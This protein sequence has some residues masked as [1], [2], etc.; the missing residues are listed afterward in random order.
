MHLLHHH[1]GTLCHA[2]ALASDLSAAAARFWV[3]R[4]VCPASGCQFWADD[5]GDGGVLKYANPKP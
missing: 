4:A 2:A 3:G 1:A 5:D